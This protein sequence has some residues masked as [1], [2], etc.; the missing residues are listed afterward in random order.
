MPITLIYANGFLATHYGLGQ[1][2][3]YI[4]AT[5][6]KTMIYIYVTNAA[7][8]TTTTLIKVSLLLQYLRLFRDGARRTTSLILLGLVAT[9]GL[10]FSF[11]AWVPCFPVSGFW[12]RT[13][14][15]PAK[16]YGYGYR[17]TTEIKSVLLVFAS[18]NMLFD[19]AI[20]L[21]PLG[22]FFR[23]DLRRKQILAMTGL[24]SLGSM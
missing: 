4:F 11:M 5:L 16:C 24:F 8:H 22:E 6:E 23:S 17:T 1:H 3:I 10:A 15:P 21:V 18:T 7:Y 12:N 9:W 13:L 19:I 14:N 20:F 2:L